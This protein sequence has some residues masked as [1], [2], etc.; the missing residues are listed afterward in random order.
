MTRLTTHDALDGARSPDWNQFAGQCRP[1]TLP[2]IPVVA[3]IHLSAF[4]G[5]F[6]SQLGNRFLCVMYKA[7]LLN[8]SGV[9]VVY[10]TDNQS[11]A[12]FAVGSL[13]QSGTDR[14]I[15]LRFLPSFLWAVMPALLRRPG[16]VLGRL[17]ARFFETGATPSIPADAMVL[18]S[19][20][21]VPAARGRAVASSLIAAFEALAAEHG[22]RH[23]FL[24]TDEE[25]ND[26]AQR[27]YQRHGYVMSSRFRQ[28]GKRWMWLMSKTI[29]LSRKE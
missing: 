3:Q 10:N 26:R 11:L 7:F 5:F 14:I 18:R 29:P 28:D 16:V 4:P 2:D 19:I 27:F 20:G 24:T 17:A 22:A 1:A 21:V 8:P 23:V 15:A 9:F 12:G 25:N 6:L 13:A